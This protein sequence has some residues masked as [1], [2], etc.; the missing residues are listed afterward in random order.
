[1][2]EH[3]KTMARFMCTRCATVVE[4]AD[5]TDCLR[6]GDHSWVPFQQGKI[7]QH[8]DLSC[9]SDPVVLFNTGAA[10]AGAGAQQGRLVILIDS[11]VLCDSV[12]VL[13]GW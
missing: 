1:V 12:V 4:G 2:Q 9:L 7:S 8:Y 6:G 10:G 5:G 13:L 11:L 3:F